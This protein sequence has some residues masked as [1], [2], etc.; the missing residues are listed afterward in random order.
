VPGDLASAVGTAAT[1]MRR[2]AAALAKAGRASR[3]LAAIPE[4][5]AP[6]GGFLRGM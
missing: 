2:V 1:P 6:S 3:R 5:A 4:V